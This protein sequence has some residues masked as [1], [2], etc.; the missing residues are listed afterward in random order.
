VAG[1]VLSTS[2]ISGIGTPI[3]RKASRW[4]LVGS[5]TIGIVARVPVNRTW[6]RVKVARCSRRLRKLR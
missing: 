6:L 1:G 2:N 4:P 5:A 3:R